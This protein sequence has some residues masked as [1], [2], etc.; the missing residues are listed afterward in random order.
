MDEELEPGA[1]PGA[2]APGSYTAGAAAASVAAAAGQSAVAAQS[3]P[4]LRAS[5]SL[6]CADAVRI[7]AEY[8]FEPHP[9]VVPADACSRISALGLQVLL[10]ESCPALTFCNAFGVANLTLAGLQALLRASVAR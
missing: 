4:C 3:A 9:G 6:A 5:S 8:S 7:P 1:E 2:A 10:G